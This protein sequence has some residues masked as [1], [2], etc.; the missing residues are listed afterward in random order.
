LKAFGIICLTTLFEIFGFVLGYFFLK[1]VD[2]GFI[3][4]ALGAAAGIMIFISTHE[5]IP[6]AELKKDSF[7]K[8][9]VIV[10]GLAI[11]FAMALIF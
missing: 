11:V 6:G 7:K 8:A 1:N 3:G 10:F 4:M 2:T 5:L 9:I